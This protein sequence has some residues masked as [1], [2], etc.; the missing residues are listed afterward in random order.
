MTHPYSRVLIV[1]AG[2]GLSAS[3]ARLF[4][5]NGLAVALAARDTA[6]LE[7]LCAETG[8]EAHACDATKGDDVARL[9]QALDGKG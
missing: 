8:A 5:L 6:K 2:H 7:N 1:G 3:L 4:A 9:F